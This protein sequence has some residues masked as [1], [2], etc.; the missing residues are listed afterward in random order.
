MPVLLA[1]ASSCFPYQ[2]GIKGEEN[3]IDAHA[4]IR[5]LEK[6]VEV[7]ER[8]KG[9]QADVLVRIDRMGQ[10]ISQVRGK[11]EEIGKQ[12]GGGSDPRVLQQLD[13][14]EEK[15]R[16]LEERIRQFEKALLSETSP[17]ASPD[18]RSEQESYEEARR[19][20]LQKRYGEAI[21]KFDV[22]QQSHPKSTLID[23]ALFWQGMSRYSNEEWEKAIIK[24][25]D[26]R[27]RFPDGD[28][29][30]DAAYFEALSFRKMND[31]KSAK[32]L[33]QDFAKKYPK[34][35]KVPL[36][37]KLLKELK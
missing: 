19:L 35:D 3:M 26:V 23:N 16:A 8:A 13:L 14:L 25:E 36:A 20:Y 10:E 11:A 12:K 37:E 30:P 9:A 21:D 5:E 27:N 4:R 18:V 17:D 1:F 31:S 6:K 32:A 22:F 28:K 24:F 2:R 33:L 15:T 29:A 34:S 7:L